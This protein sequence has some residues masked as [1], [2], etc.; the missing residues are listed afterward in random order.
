MFA[1]GCFSSLITWNETGESVL[2]E[3]LA[4][5]APTFSPAAPTAAQIAVWVLGELQSETQVLA[6]L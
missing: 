2:P 4:H 5:L 3:Q 6:V 1:V